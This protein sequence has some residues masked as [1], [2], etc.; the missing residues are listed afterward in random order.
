MVNI[1]TNMESVAETR[2]QKK[3]LAPVIYDG[4]VRVRE[5]AARDGVFTLSEHKELGYDNETLKTMLAAI[6]QAKASLDFWKIYVAGPFN[7]VREYRPNADDPKKMKPVSPKELAAI[8]EQAEGL[9][10]VRVRRP[11]P[12]VKLYAWKGQD[13]KPRMPGEKGSPAASKAQVRE[14]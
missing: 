7:G 10:L 1:N 4:R 2:N 11:F 9:S 13:N 8:I 3:V 14:L 6:L 12:Q 5:R